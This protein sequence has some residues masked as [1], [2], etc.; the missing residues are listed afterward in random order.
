[1]EL[2]EKLATVR[3]SSPRD[4]RG[5]L[6]TVPLARRNFLGH[7]RRLIR[8]L[9]G[10][11]FAAV[12]MMVEIGF[13][14]S[15]IE[16]NLLPIEDL[17]G[18]IMVISSTKYEFD[19]PLPFSRRQLYEARAVP[20]VASVRP[21]Y[22]KKAIWK[23]PQNLKLFDVQVFAFDPDQPVFLMPE[24][25]AYLDALRRPD[26]VIVDRRARKEVGTA[27]AGTE[28]E[29]SR[30]NIRVAGTFQVGPNFFSNGTVLMSD[31]NYFKLFGILSL[32]PADLPDV[33]VGVVKLL[34][35]QKVPDVKR[36]LTAAMPPNVITLSKSELIENER[37]FLTEVTAVGPVFG[38][39]TLVGFAVGMLISY[40]I[41][42]SE[43]FDQLPQYATL[44]AMGYQNSYLLKIVLQQAALYA[45]AG[46]VP[47]WLVCFVIFKLMGDIAL[48]PMTMSLGL[49]AI[50]LALTLGMCIGA[51]LIAARRV[52][53]ADPAELLR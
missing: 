31:R 20:G 21:L 10:I 52:I 39:G 32:N 49:T 40:Q 18:E 35:G 33:D 43:L 22:I 3:L 48:I 14:I 53:A 29:L 27:S 1:M 2:I 51:A 41:L 46:Y 37:K 6:S 44:T 45:L 36:A 47:A 4:G 38:V 28:T 26:T 9:A 13:Y 23:N 24:I 25:N 12:L 19:R 50:S 42:F 5:A 11:A 34:P 17:D 15:F 8:S 16:S 30:Q 7:G